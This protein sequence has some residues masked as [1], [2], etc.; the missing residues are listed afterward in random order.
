MQ[1][2]RPGV[3]MLDPIKQKPIGLTEVMEKFGV[4]PEKLIDAQALIGDSGR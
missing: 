4:G 1:L 2:I 3:A